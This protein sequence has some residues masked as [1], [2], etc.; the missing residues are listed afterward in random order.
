ML[1]SRATVIKTILDWPVGGHTNGSNLQ[2]VGGF[3]MRN[4]PLVHGNLTEYANAPA[5]FQS[6]V[7]LDCTTMMSQVYR[8]ARNR[9]LIVALGDVAFS[10]PWGRLAIHR[11]VGAV[12]GD[13][14]SV[15]GR[16]KASS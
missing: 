3:S 2:V 8:D 15:P 6:V 13:H 5:D 14:A 10:M 4:N 16:N 9:I 12:R 1:I 7:V 11:A